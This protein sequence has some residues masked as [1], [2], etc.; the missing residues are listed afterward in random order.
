VD[1]QLEALARRLEEL[2]AEVRELR[3]GIRQ[4]VAIAARDPEMSLTRARKVLEYMLRDVYERQ[5][6]EPAGTRPLENLVQRLARDGHLPKRLAAYAN[7]IRELGNVGTHAFG[8]EVTAQDVFQSLTQLVPLVEWYFRQRGPAPAAAAAPRAEALPD[9]EGGRQ[10]EEPQGAAGRPGATRRP[11][12]SRWGWLALGAGAGLC[13]VLVSWAALRPSTGTPVTAPGGETGHGPG[14]AAKDPRAPAL[15]G[16]VPREPDPTHVKGDRPRPLD[17]TGADGVSAAEVRQA[18]EAWA[19]YLGR[20]VEE[21]VEIAG[22]VKMTFVLVPPG[23]FRMGSPTEEQDYVTRTFFDGRRPAW[24]NDERQHEVT[25]TEPYYLGKT[26]VTQA[27]YEALTGENPS[28]F[29]G[30]DRPV[31]QGS[32]EEARDCAARLTEKL[33]DG[34]LYRLP[35]EAEWEYAYRGGRT[36]SQPFGVGD[37]RALSS[38]EANFDGNYP[39]G[40]ADKGPSLQATCAVASYRPNALGV[41]DMQGNVWE[42]CADRHGPYPRGEVTNP[43]GPSEGSARVVRGGSWLDGAWSCRAAGRLGNAPGLRRYDLGFR[44]LRSVPSGSK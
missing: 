36:S 10:Q 1:P 37:G 29:K 7:A 9:G 23:K 5:I 8:E 20:E 17:C 34:H 25:L 22:G 18:Q 26:E 31:E 19:K 3:E 13:A 32:W 15:P 14:A 35:T 12:R 44:L 41:F 30:A 11:A 39:Y 28:H 6:G 24:L 38:R 42:W 27:Q 43:A 33:H 21:M 2:S 4:S 40:G 16:D